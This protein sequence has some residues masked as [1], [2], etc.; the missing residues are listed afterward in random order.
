M[1]RKRKAPPEVPAAALTKEIYEILDQVTRDEP[2]KVV[3]LQLVAAAAAR[4]RTTWLQ[5]LSE[6]L[7]FLQPGT[8]EFQ[9]FKNC[10]QSMLTLFV[11]NG[12]ISAG[13]MQHIW[14]EI[15]AR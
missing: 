9:A 13:E 3:D 8:P 11:Q 12:I 7:G 14:R 15:E 2:V 5:E 1:V 4:L 6:A 10:T